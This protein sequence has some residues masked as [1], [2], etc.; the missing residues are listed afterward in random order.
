MPRVEVLVVGA[1]PAGTAATIE[2][3]RLGLDVLT[4]DKARF[5]RD[6]TCGDGLTTGALR[7]LQA[8][9]VDVRT[10]ASYA[11]I[12]ETVVVSPSGREVTLPL[13]RDGEFAGVVTRTELDAALVETA[14][15]EG[16]AVDDGVGV[17]QVGV[18]ADDLV[19]QLDDGRRVQ[20]RWV[21]AADGHYSPVRRM[22]NGACTPMPSELGTW[23]A[24][25]QYFR[26]VGDERLWVV[27]D[28]D[29]LPGYAWVFPLGGGR[30]NVGFGVLRDSRNGERLG[31][32][33]AAQWREV[34]GHPRVRAILGARAAPDGPARAWPIPAAFDAQRLTH[35][36]VLFAGDAAG[37]VDPMTGEGIAQA[38]DTGVLAARAIEADATPAAVCARYRRDVERTLGAD[39][40][41]ARALQSIL[42]SPLGARA[43]LRA[44]SLTPWTRRNFGRWM[45]EDYPRAVALTPRRWHRGMFAG[46]GAYATTRLVH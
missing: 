22:L 45:F 42:R 20:A 5:P 24:F 9:G 25:R 37:V 46:R 8:L 39:L 17:A 11:S 44:A 40:R 26:D 30:A 41:F 38:L 36:R 31:K 2:A 43:A 35:G 29:L 19:V 27:F 7:Q 6:K 21:V 3:R 32:R 16:A 14:R 33:L 18:R 13:P 15:A 34:V 4:V 10:L 12:A 1:G 23:H 28:P